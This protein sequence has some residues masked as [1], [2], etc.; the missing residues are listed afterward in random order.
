MPPGRMPT[1]FQLLS[2]MNLEVFAIPSGMQQGHSLCTGNRYSCGKHKTLKIPYPISQ[3]QQFTL[4]YWKLTKV[5]CEA[6]RLIHYSKRHTISSL[7][8]QTTVRLLLP[9]KLAKHA[10]S[11]GTKAVTKYTS[12]K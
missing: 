7:E 1:L 8:I 10:V 11:E 9:G 5:A 12:C 4:D 6:S 2:Q 3:K